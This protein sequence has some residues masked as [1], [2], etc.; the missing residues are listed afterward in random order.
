MPQE[1]DYFQRLPKQGY[2][3]HS[4]I[5]F[6]FSKTMGQCPLAKKYKTMKVRDEIT[7]KK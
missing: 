2:N 4:H 6:F 5:F 7:R 1:E 3:I